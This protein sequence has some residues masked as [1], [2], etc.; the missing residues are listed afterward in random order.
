MNYKCFSAS[1]VGRGPR[2]IR[3]AVLENWYRHFCES[4]IGSL[5]TYFL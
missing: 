4:F 1:N 3:V 2:Q 5:E